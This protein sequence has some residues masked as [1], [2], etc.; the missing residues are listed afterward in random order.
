MRFVGILFVFAFL[1]SISVVSAVDSEVMNIRCGYS[2]APVACNESV[3]FSCNISDVTL[4]TLGISSVVF[5]L[6][7]AV[8][9]D[10][11]ASLV[12]GTVFNGTWEYTIGGVNSYSSVSLSRVVVTNGLGLVCDASANKD[13]TF[14]YVRF[15]TQADVLMTCER[16][17]DYDYFYTNHTDNSVIETIV[18]T[19]GCN[20]QTIVL[21]RYGDFCDPGWTPAY[22]CVPANEGRYNDFRDAWEVYGRGDDSSYLYETRYSY[23]LSGFADK[24]FVSSNP[25]CCPST[26]L[27]S[28]CDP[29]LGE[30]GVVSC[31]LD[32][33]VGDGKSS[34]LSRYNDF[35]GPLSN[36]TEFS[37]GLSVSLKPL[38]FDIDEDRFNNVVLY[39]GAFL[40]S[41][42][43]TMDLVEWRV[44]NDWGTGG[45][46]GF[47]G[48]AV[49]D[50]SEI[51]WADPPN[52]FEFLPASWDY[53]RFNYNA[54]GTKAYVSTGEG[55]LWGSE[56]YAV[57]E[58]DVFPAW[59]VSGF[60]YAGVLEVYFPTDA[61]W[62]WSNFAG[63]P[64]VI[65][66]DFSPTG[67]NVLWT[68]GA[69]YLGKYYDGTG[70]GAWGGEWA[71]EG[72]VF[73]IPLNVFYDLSSVAGTRDSPISIA[74]F[75]GN[76]DTIEE[77]LDAGYD[78]FELLGTC[79]FDALLS[80][81]GLRMYEWDRCGGAVALDYGVDKSYTNTSV[82]QY[83]LSVAFDVSTAS[84]VGSFSL[85]TSPTTSPGPPANSKDFVMAKDGS[86]MYLLQDDNS[87]AQTPEDV[88]QWNLAV[89][90]NVSS[91]VYHGVFSATSVGG[92]T[93]SIGFPWSYYECYRNYYRASDLSISPDGSKFMV[94]GFVNHGSNPY[95]SAIFQY[96][97]DIVVTGESITNVSVQPV[98]F[99]I[100]Q[101][102]SPT[103]DDVCFGEPFS[104]GSLDD[105]SCASVDGCWIGQSDCSGT[106]GSC[107]RITGSGS[108]A[109]AGCDWGVP[110]EQYVWGGGEFALS[111]CVGGDLGSVSAVCV[112]E[113]LVSCWSFYGDQTNCNLAGCDY[114]IGGFCTS[115]PSACRS[116]TNVFAC[117]SVGCTWD[118]DFVENSC[119]IC[120][121][122][123]VTD[124]RVECCEN[125]ASVLV[126]APFCFGPSTS[127]GGLDYYDCVL[128]GCTPD[129]SPPGF[130]WCSGTAL[131]CDSVVFKDNEQGCLDHVGCDWDESLCSGLSALFAVNGEIIHTYVGGYLLSG[132]YVQLGEIRT[133]VNEF[134]LAVMYLHAGGTPHQTTLSEGQTDVYTVEGVDYE[135]TLLRSYGPSIDPDCETTSCT[136][137]P[138]LNSTTRDNAI[139]FAVIEETDDGWSFLASTWVPYLNYSLSNRVKVDLNAGLI[140]G[141]INGVASEI[142]CWAN[143][144]YF[145]SVTSEVSP[146]VY[147]WEVD[148]TPY[149]LVAPQ[150]SN[151]LVS[152]PSI[153]LDINVSG[154]GDIAIVQLDQVGPA[155]VVFTVNGVGTKSLVACG[156]D[157]I[158]ECVVKEIPVS[159][160]NSSSS[161]LVSAGMSVG[162]YDSIPGYARVYA[163]LSDSDSSSGYSSSVFSSALKWDLSTGG[164]EWVDAA[165]FTLVFNH[166]DSGVNGT[167][168][169]VSAPSVGPCAG[170]AAG[171]YSEGF[172]FM[173]L[174]GNLSSGVADTELYC[175]RSTSDTR[176]FELDAQYSGVYDFDEDIPPSVT[177]VD[178][179]N[180]GFAELVT[181]EG[182]FSKTMDSFNFS[183]FGISLA[184]TYYVLPSDISS[185]G[186][187]DFLASTLTEFKTL[188]SI[189]AY[190]VSLNPPGVGTTLDGCIAKFDSESWQVEV[191]GQN[192]GAE[193]L[194]PTDLDYDAV[195]LF[196]GEDGVEA[197]KASGRQ[198]SLLLDVDPLLSG[199]Y[200][201]S[202]KVTDP[203]A[204]NGSS[205][206]T[207][208]C[209]VPGLIPLRNPPATCGLGTAGEFNF[210]NMAYTNWKRFEGEEFFP[211]L[212]NGIA[213]FAGGDNVYYPLKCEN[214]TVWLSGL[215]S[216]E[217]S[218]QGII[219]LSVTDEYDVVSVIGGLSIDHLD[220]YM[221][222]PTGPV[223]VHQIDEGGSTW[224]EWSLKF[225]RDAYQY[226]LFL[227]NLA[228]HTV[229]F[230]NRVDGVVSRLG[231]Q[232]TFG[233]FLVDWVRLEGEGGSR[234]KDY[235]TINDYALQTLVSCFNGTRDFDVDPVGEI[236]Q[237]ENINEYCYR[238]GVFNEGY[239]TL[240][241]LK[242]AI[243]FNPSCY[244]EASNYCQAW[245]YPLS[246]GF[247]DEGDWY[248]DVLNVSTIEGTSACSANLVAGAAFNNLLTPAID[249]MWIIFQR[250]LFVSILLLGFTLL[251]VGGVVMRRKR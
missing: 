66:M 189:P 250:N 126:D 238:L 225:D 228:V 30:Q 184:N 124:D 199:Q 245:T 56:L 122:I 50:I 185:E 182:I 141:G 168:A 154:V 43:L 103:S 171:V 52:V 188:L 158:S 229:D 26:N 233:T 169:M 119:S 98:L 22:A 190:L 219:Y 120:N 150:Y 14:C 179:D 160:D 193:H 55:E 81:D 230:Q 17:C 24:T 113:S 236:G 7:D 88:H 164:V 86:S 25:S 235:D 15:S 77:F 99:G 218:G 155:A 178:L 187:I 221:Q 42:D 231:V 47:S 175:Y 108:C 239:C 20:E 112:G 12:N 148:V 106:S 101:V 208:V 133:S 2:T 79:S 28:D 161:T 180:D 249:G 74:E 240:A 118:D 194:G 173:T 243:K 202:Y 222:T 33:W 5:H 132:S 144:C 227:D 46:G 58:Y 39:D 36:L 6:D 23:P 65:N 60:S 207:A 35:G 201:V 73:S 75:V 82:N 163:S 165:D 105:L 153:P 8:G 183:E 11:V 138:T 174:F 95:F 241:Q 10:K 64:G 84:L 146:S 242:Q 104:C 96:D 107:S 87:G 139:G 216:T 251:V 53:H 117:E 115:E 78:S 237:Y 211:S 130:S 31:L 170:S 71:Y 85:L 166:S 247:E 191:V 224:L 63:S 149:G 18:P 159:P 54:L 214:N 127:C 123:S 210:D 57:V 45:G 72:F 186:H 51:S 213:S 136:M 244:Y 206:A 217:N 198:Q 167:V 100:N 204:Q 232:R 209:A 248:D 181:Q 93:C 21:T 91:A 134:P 62:S 37:S 197:A 109:I 226:T 145:V 131:S 61:N 176:L 38:V 19:A 111:E 143:T 147:V 116:F 89:P 48:P 234:T 121:D 205:S 177:M 32:Y 67:D 140:S 92:H 102:E 196:G 4:S 80:P 13:S 114:R 94:T 16:S 246:N 27:S 192:V 157:W 223:R 125:S 172:S 203:A 29:P 40:Y 151:K 70:N 152:I 200:F 195:L 128:S 41:Y 68:F 34:D 1:L 212:D 49:Y 135:V 129:D 3:T 162:N 220:I 90:W 59:N 97:A 137:V 142:V 110:D 76:N 215:Y 44:F 9:S 83:A 156:L 69:D